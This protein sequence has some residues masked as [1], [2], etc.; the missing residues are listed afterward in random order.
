ML[1]SVYWSVDIRSA[2]SSGLKCRAHGDSLLGIEH[3]SSSWIPGVHGSERSYIDF[4]ISDIISKAQ[5]NKISLDESR[6]NL[7]VCN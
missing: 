5:Y 1:G 6:L 3:Y 2:I 4:S 7:I